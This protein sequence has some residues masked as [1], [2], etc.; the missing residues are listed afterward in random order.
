M[1]FAAKNIDFAA[2]H[3]FTHPAFS[4]SFDARECERCARKRASRR[5]A[6]PEFLLISARFRRRA[7]RASRA[8]Q[9]RQLALIRSPAR[10]SFF[11]R[12]P[13]R[14]LLTSIVPPFA[15]MPCCACSRS[16]VKTGRR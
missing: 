6:A 5:E 15:E 11:I 4:M 13:S 14:A 10:P 12:S 3:V 7:P 1:M 16:H 9:I 2:F 8:L